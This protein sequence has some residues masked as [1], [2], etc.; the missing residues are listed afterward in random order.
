MTQVVHLD[1]VQVIL[2]PYQIHKLIAPFKPLLIHLVTALGGS[3]VSG[4]MRRLI[5]HSVPWI[6]IMTICFCRRS[7]RGTELQ[8]K[9]SLSGEM[10]ADTFTC[11][12]VYLVYCCGIGP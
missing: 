9:C 5:R 4:L 11:R 1:E 10:S 7:L 3:A 12:Q 8:D 2:T 6:P